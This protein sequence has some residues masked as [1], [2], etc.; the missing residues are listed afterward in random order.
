MTTKWITKKPESWITKKEIPAKK[1]KWIT[2]KSNPNWITKKEAKEH[3]TTPARKWI[4]KKKPV[5]SRS[6]H[7]SVAEDK[8]LSPRDKYKRD[9][10]GQD[11]SDKYKEIKVSNTQTGLSKGRKK[12]QHGGR[13]GLKEGGRGTYGGWDRPSRKIP[14]HLRDKIKDLTKKGRPSPSRPGGKG[15]E[16]PDKRWNKGDKFMTPL[17]AK[18]GIGSLVKKVIS[19]IKPKPKGKGLGSGVKPSEMKDIIPKKDR[20]LYLKEKLAN[21]LPTHLRGPNPHRDAKLRNKESKKVFKSAKGKASGGRIR[22]GQGG[23]TTQQHYLQHG[24]GPTKA[25][26][27]AGKPKIA[28]KGW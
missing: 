4:T 27:R 19:K 21:P 24:F 6:R 3:D 22:R 18:H 9:V 2:K 1:T 13:I 26:L 7:Q 23:S 12:F 11:M 28:I 10:L 16:A 20:K 17:R 8:R 25:K 14:K 15:K 5:R